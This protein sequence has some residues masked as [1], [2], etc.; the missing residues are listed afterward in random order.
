MVGKCC[1]HLEGL[2][3][4]GLPLMITNLTHLGGDKRN[5]MRETFSVPIATSL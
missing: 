4:K 2:F 5:G 3:L 1:S